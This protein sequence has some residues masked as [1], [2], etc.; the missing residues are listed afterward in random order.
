[1]KN[2]TL[3]AFAIVIFSFTVNLPAQT[4]EQKAHVDSLK[5][6]ILTPPPR[7]T[8]RINGANVFGVRPGAPFLYLIPVTG[9]RPMT[10]KVKNSTFAS[11][12]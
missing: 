1:M 11:S 9:K 12:N 6:F 5:A 4:P 10:F 8:P 3:F 2:I 7:E